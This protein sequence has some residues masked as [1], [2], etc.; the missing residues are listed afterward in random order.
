ML[1]I[2][3]L[4]LTVILFI[5]GCRID[6]IDNSRR[7]GMTAAVC[8]FITCLCVPSVFAPNVYSEERDWVSSIELT[9]LNSND[10]SD[11]FLKLS[12]TDKTVSYAFINNVLR[13]EVKSISEEDCRIIQD[14]EVMPHIEVYERE[15]EK[16]WYY[17][18]YGDP[19]TE[20]VI[21]VPARTITE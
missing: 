19:K 8:L 4:V 10:D 6:D 12:E 1:F 7:V 3:S 5:V 2:I 16:K 18:F 14:D 15:V 9:P 11:I 20:Y 17:L 13:K 21:Y